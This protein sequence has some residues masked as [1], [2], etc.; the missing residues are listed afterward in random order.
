MLIIRALLSGSVI[1][2]QFGA[3]APGRGAAIYFVFNIASRRVLYQTCLFMFKLNKMVN[4][5]VVPL[6]VMPS[7]HTAK[8][9][10]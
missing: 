3:G 8:L 1:C 6:V 10:K 9:A 5:V 7:V 2:V 4:L